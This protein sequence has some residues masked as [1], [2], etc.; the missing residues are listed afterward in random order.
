MWANAL[1]N[2]NAGI[3]LLSLPVA[4]PH[5][6]AWRTRPIAPLPQCP[7]APMP[8]S[9]CG[10]VPGEALVRGAVHPPDLQSGAGR[11]G[12]PNTIQI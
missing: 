10:W 11:V 6:S 4:P 12:K 3:L 2:N 8:H 7:S 5:C 9:P 1:H